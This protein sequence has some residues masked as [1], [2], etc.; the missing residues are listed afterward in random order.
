MGIQEEVHSGK[1]LHRPKQS[2][3]KARDKAKESKTQAPSQE[4]RVA[5]YL[6]YHI[7][8]SFPQQYL[9]VT[10]GKKKLQC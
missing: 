1:N 3:A 9:I 4:F 8:T 5:F 6:F 7:Y 2:E 10:L